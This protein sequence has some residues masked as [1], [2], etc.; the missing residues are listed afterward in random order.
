MSRLGALAIHVLDTR[1]CPV[2]VQPKKLLIEHA[3][4]T[5][6]EV[7]ACKL[8]LLCCCIAY[9]FSRYPKSHAA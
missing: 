3:S 7:P 5:L 8:H 9:L 6:A 1:L 2:H 4:A